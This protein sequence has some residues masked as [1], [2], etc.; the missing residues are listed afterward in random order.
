MIK[1]TIYTKIF[2]LIL[3]TSIQSYSAV[4]QM[5]TSSVNKLMNE[6][7]IRLQNND[8]KQAIQ[9][10]DQGREML[11]KIAI[12]LDEKNQNLIRSNQ[13][14]RD[15]EKLIQQGNLNGA[16]TLL[17]EAIELNMNNV[18]AL[19]YRGSI[20]LM[21]EQEIPRPKDRNYIGLI[22]DYTNAIRVID[23]RINNAPRNSQERKEYEREKAKILINR[24]Y[25]KMQANRSAAFFSAIEDYTEAIRND[26]EN[27]DGY[28]GRAV[29]YNRIK[30]NRREVNDYLRS[31]ELMQKYQYKIT[32]TEWSELYLTVAVAYANLRDKRNAYD[33]ASRSFN[34]GNLAAAPIMDKNKP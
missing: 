16:H 3:F 13:L 28:L 15:A 1:S 31:F 29:A 9:L 26:V 32:D 14:T 23:L 5:D 33:F 19:K 21:L 25:V 34:L 24:A 27:W 11:Y 2:I 22:N 20:R 7:I 10:F 6:G 4:A 18:E 8:I 17:N 30:D 12:E